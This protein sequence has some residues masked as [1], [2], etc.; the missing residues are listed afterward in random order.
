MFFGLVQFEMRSLFFS[1][2]S[3]QRCSASLP[4]SVFRYVSS[5][6]HQ[7]ITTVIDTKKSIFY[8]ITQ[9][10]SHHWTHE[11][12][13]SSEMWMNIM[14]IFRNFTCLLLVGCHSVIIHVDHPIQ[15]T[16]KQQRRVYVHVNLM[17][18]IIFF[19]FSGESCWTFSGCDGCG[20]LSSPVR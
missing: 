2:S 6:S 4:F 11:W 7:A 17:E 3:Q 13:V 16:W 5:T 10:F 8:Q 18:M 20:K 15:P 12:R 19:Q 14:R 9:F 1:L